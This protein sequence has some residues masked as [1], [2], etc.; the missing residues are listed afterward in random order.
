VQRLFFERNDEFWSI[1][2]PTNL[3]GYFIHNN[4]DCP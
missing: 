1:E 3:D 4:T 2:L